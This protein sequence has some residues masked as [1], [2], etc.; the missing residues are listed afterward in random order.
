MNDG[1]LFL[2]VFVAMAI[3]DWIWA[4]YIATVSENKALAAASWSAVIIIV[5][6]FTTLSYVHS[7][8]LIFA[9]ALGAFVG[10]AGSVFWKLRKKDAGT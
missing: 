7:P 4:L 10:T 5:G 3:N 6:G 9:A 8:M 2:A 1:V